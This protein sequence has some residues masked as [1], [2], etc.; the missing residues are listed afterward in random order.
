MFSTIEVMILIAAGAS[1][2]HY[3]FSRHDFSMAKN[4]MDCVDDL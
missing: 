3:L 2:R 4:P 1:F